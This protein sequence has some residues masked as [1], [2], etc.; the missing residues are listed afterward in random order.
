MY[1]RRNNRR[2]NQSPSPSPPRVNRSTRGRG[3]IST[4]GRSPSR[5]ATR[6]QSAPPTRRTRTPSP[7]AP[8]RAETYRERAASVSSS[9]VDEYY[10][11]QIR[12]TRSPSGGPRPYVSSP[13]ESSSS[14]PTSSTGYRG[15]AVQPHRRERHPRQ[16]RAGSESPPP[17]T[18]PRPSTARASTQVP[19]TPMER[20]REAMG[21]PWRDSPSPPPRSRRCN[22]CGGSGRQTRPFP[23]TSPGC[24]VRTGRILPR[25]SYNDG[26]R[27]QE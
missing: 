8:R 11:R 20:A 1:S 2:R 23:C 4:R 6:R 22:E 18:R 17:P 27:R 15:Q 25:C 13:S 5:P 19:N 16:F 9:S 10:P 24:L 26:F 3:G 7:Q 14:A 21:R 12:R